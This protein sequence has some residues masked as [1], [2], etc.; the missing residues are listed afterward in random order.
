MFLFVSRLDEAVGCSDEH[1][2]DACVT[3][4]GEKVCFCNADLCNTGD[5]ERPKF[6]SL[7]WKT[8]IRGSLKDRAEQL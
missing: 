2:P 4:S 7:L 5:Q 8:L 6:E 1:I 3:T